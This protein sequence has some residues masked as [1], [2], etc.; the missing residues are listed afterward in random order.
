MIKIMFGATETPLADVRFPE[1]MELHDAFR[2]FSRISRS[3]A[4]RRS[5]SGEDGK[6]E[7]S[8]SKVRHAQTVEMKSHSTSKPAP[9][10]T[11]PAER[12]AHV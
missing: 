1:V 8:K 10:A 5:L 3:F 11:T 4:D 7:D 9:L 6:L 12:R 2:T